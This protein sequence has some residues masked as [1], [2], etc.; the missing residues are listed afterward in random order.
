MQGKDRFIN[1]LNGMSF[2][3]L[4]E[5]EKTLD[6]KLYKAKRDPQSTDESI[7][8]LKEHLLLVSNRI[9]AF[10]IRN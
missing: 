1:S 5:L 8:I 2:E 9:T 10:K 3:E 4:K 7:A 6:S